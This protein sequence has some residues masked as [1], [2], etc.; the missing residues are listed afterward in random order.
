MT[1][2]YSDEILKKCE[3]IKEHYL[4]GK[5]YIREIFLEMRKHNRAIMEI[6]VRLLTVAQFNINY[7]KNPI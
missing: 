2:I 3:E 4:S 6:M 7:Y 1:E 5:N